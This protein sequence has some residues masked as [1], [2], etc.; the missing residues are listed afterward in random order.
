MPKTNVEQVEFRLDPERFPE[1]LTT[2]EF[3]TVARNT[4]EGVRYWRH[5]GKGPRSFR[6]GRRVLYAREAVEAWFRQ[7]MQEDKIA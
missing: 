2:E 7:Q 1:F 5:I 4:P 6:A 3:A